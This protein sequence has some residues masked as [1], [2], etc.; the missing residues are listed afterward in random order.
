MALSGNATAAASGGSNGKW[1]V[2][3]VWKW[4]TLQ[5]LPGT[6]RPVLPSFC[7]FSTNS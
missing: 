1:L 4:Q 6:K 5:S 7:A 3:E 2:V